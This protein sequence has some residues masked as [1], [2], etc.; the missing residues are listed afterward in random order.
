M[1]AQ[2]RKTERDGANAQQGIASNQSEASETTIKKLEW[3][4]EVAPGLRVQYCADT[5]L[6]GDDGKPDPDS[7][8]QVYKLLY[9]GH[10]D[11]NQGE[12][13]EL[14]ANIDTRKRMVVEVA[15]DRLRSA[16][17]ELLAVAEHLCPTALEDLPTL[18]VEELQP[19]GKRARVIEMEDPRMLFCRHHAEYLRNGNTTRAIVCP[20][21]GIVPDFSFTDKGLQREIDAGKYGT[22]AD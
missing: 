9:E 3:S 12:R 19:D 7:L 22:A 14:L 21:P 2:E 6:N 17:A 1:T 15:A 5:A 20:E 11:R 16:A 8:G 4:P 10:V 13:F 18:L